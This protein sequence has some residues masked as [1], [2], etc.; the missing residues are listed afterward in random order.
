MEKPIDLTLSWFQDL[1]LPPKRCGLRIR[2]K[3]L[4]LGLYWPYCDQIVSF[5]YTD[6]RSVLPFICCLDLDR[7]ILLPKVNNFVF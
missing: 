2:K 1:K 4:E 3:S 6:F 5:K 7:E